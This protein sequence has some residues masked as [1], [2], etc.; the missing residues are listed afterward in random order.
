MIQNLC[1]IIFHHEGHEG[2]KER[3]HYYI[4]KPSCIFVFF[5]VNKESSLVKKITTNGAKVSPLE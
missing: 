2:H 4:E 1:Y 5:V 3:I